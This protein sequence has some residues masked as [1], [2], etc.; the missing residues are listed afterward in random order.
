MAYELLLEHLSKHIPVSEAEAANLFSYL[1]YR[2]IKKRRFILSEGSV[3]KNL[4]F[5]TQGCLRS[6]S[7][8]KNGFEHILQFA[9]PGWWIAD[10]QS[11]LKQTPAAF[12]IDAVDDTE[13]ILLAKTDLEELYISMPALERFF[14]ILAEN[15]LA[16]YQRRLMD[17]LSLS[18]LERYNNFC[19]L[20]PSLVQCLP[21][22]QIAAYIGVTPEFLSKM[23]N[24]PMPKS[25]NK[26]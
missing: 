11:F 3:Q 22:K 8:D 17:N 13:I 7:I 4:L 26:P 9:P 16:T 6:Y 10:M 5:V 21:Q 19:R 24:S 25:N 20:Y 2:K 23:L 12:Y 1:E 18:A 15:A 14:R